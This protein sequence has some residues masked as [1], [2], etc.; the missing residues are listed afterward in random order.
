MPLRVTNGVPVRVSR[1]PNLPAAAGFGLAPAAAPP[2]L[3]VPYVKQTQTQWCW[4]ACAEMVARYLGAAAVKQCE[5]AN[6]L[7]GQTKC[8]TS[9]ASAACNLPTDYP[10]VFKVYTHLGIKCIGHT[11]AVNG[12]VVLKELKAGR[13]VEVGYTWAGGTGGHVA[14][15]TGVTPAGLLAIHD[16]WPDYGTGFATYQYVFSAYGMG[17]WTYSFGDFQKLSP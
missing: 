17:R 14:L 6:V 1:R 8:C 2:M 10:G 3:S 15:I 12:Q 5:L 11:W 9:P 16:P 13:P 7:H 4:A